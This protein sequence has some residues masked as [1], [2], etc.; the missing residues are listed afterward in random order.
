MRVGHA[1]AGKRDCRRPAHG[2]GSAETETGPLRC[3]LRQPASAPADSERRAPP[4]PTRQLTVSGRVAGRLP[5]RRAGAAHR[6]L[7]ERNPGTLLIDVGGLPVDRMGEARARCLHL[8]D[9]VSI[10]RPLL[11]QYNRPLRLGRIVLQYIRRPDQLQS[12]HARL[13]GA[14][15]GRPCGHDPGAK[16]RCGYVPAP[17]PAADSALCANRGFLR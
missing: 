12:E 6:E 8:A 4:P 14:G 3:R 1:P 2:A 10:N 16:D 17:E 7:R 5:C 13:P 11:L 15:H 9:T